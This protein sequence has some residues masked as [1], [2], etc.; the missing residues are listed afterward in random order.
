M[1]ETAPE[2]QKYYIGKILPGLAKLLTDEKSIRVKSEA[3]LAVNNFLAGLITKNKNAENNMQILKPYITQL[4][5]LILKL[6]E[7]SLNINYE[8][9]QKNSLDCISLLSNIHENNFGD[10]YQ[11]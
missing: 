4:I 9:L 6:F 2:P 10:Y 3:C 8:P 1:T 11:K 7:E 5:D